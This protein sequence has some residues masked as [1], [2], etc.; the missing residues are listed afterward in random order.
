[1]SLWLFLRS[2]ADHRWVATMIL[3]GPRWV[4]LTPLALLLPAALLLRRRSLIA[5][6]AA[7]ALIVAPVM[8]LCIPWRSAFAPAA[9]SGTAQKLRVITCNVHRTALDPDA[10]AALI[11]SANPD[12]VALQEWTSKFDSIF[13]STAGWYALRDDELCLV[14]R[15]P[16]RR[17]RDVGTENWNKKE[18]PGAAV[19]YELAMPQGPIPLVNL[20]LASPHRA[21]EAALQRS[22]EGPEKIAQNSVMRLKQSQAVGRF[23]KGQGPAVLVAGDFNTPQ[24]SDLFAR[25]WPPLTDAYG[26]AGFGW[27]YTYHARWT[28]VRIDHILSGRTAR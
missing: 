2:E 9:T 21:F 24:E 19:C 18:T 17:L 6:S 14:S 22:P 25:S 15:Y 13:P 7:A 4:A 28:D 5:L 20:H 11:K 1:M 3:F 16:I 8:G 26:A 12:V 23:A 10:L 27:G